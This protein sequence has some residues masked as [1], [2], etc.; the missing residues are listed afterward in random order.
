MPIPQD[1][2]PETA[3]AL[4]TLTGYKV[5][6]PKDC[7]ELI[8]WPLGSPVEL[9]AE[10]FK[11]GCVRLHLKSEVLPKI[12]ARRAEIQSS[13]PPNS[14]E[15]LGVINDRY[16]E[17][18]LYTKGGHS[19]EFKKRVVVYLGLLPSDEQQLF[20]EGTKETIDIMS[21]TYRNARLDL[22]KDSTSA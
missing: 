4:A 9:I 14:L 5:H 7:M 1:G 6:I 19:V 11:A 20:V 18:S 17:V 16:N 21:L 2:E 3:S 15:L 10:L 22:L 13:N 12:L 8:S